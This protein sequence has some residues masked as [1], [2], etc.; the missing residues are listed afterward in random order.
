MTGESEQLTAEELDLLCPI[1][2]VVV[3]LLGSRMTGPR[4]T[5]FAPRDVRSPLTVEA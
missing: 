5:C 4:P 2:Y 1:V 3:E